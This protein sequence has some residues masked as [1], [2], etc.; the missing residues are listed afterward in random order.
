M[1]IGFLIPL[2]MVVGANTVYHI[3]AKGTSLEVSPFLSLM[4]TYFVSFLFCGALYLFKGEVDFIGDVKKTGWTAWI[5]GFAIVLI[6]SGY[7]FMYR[8]GWKISQGSLVANISVAIILAVI[9]T[10]AYKEVLSPKQLVGIA[11]CIV[12]IIL[13]K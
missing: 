11:V 12:G 5:L 1:S 13:L 3:A 9:G 7:I 8:N 10:L 2:L 6:E 4:V